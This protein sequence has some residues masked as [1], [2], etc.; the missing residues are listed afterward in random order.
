MTWNPD[1]IVVGEEFVGYVEELRETYDHAAGGVQPGSSELNMSETQSGSDEQTQTD[2]GAQLEATTETPETPAA[3]NSAMNRRAFMI[4]AGMTAATVAAGPVSAQSN[5]VINTDSEY[6]HDP[7]QVGTVTVAEH[8]PEFNHFGYINDSG[9]EATL[10]TASLAPREDEST[11][12]NPVRIRGDRILFSDRR[13]FPRDLTTTNAD[14]E[15]VDASALDAEFW[16]TDESSTAGTLTLEDASEGRLRVATSGQGAGDSAVATFTDFTLE[17]GE[18]RSMLQLILNIDT[19]DSSA[20][21]DVEVTDAASNSVVATIDSAADSANLGT[22]AT[23][24]GK[25]VIYQEQLGEFDNGANLDTIEEISVT[26]SEGNADVTFHA[27]NL[28]STSKW[29]FGTREFVNSDDEIEEK[30][31]T[32]QKGYFGIVSL[33]TL[34]ESDRLSDATLYQVE[35]PGAEIRPTD[36]FIDLA[37]AE[38][39]D[40]EERLKVVRNWDLDSAYDLT[41][42]LDRVVDDVAHPSSRYLTMEIASGLDDPVE[43]DETDDVEWTNRT[44]TYTDASIDDEVE[45]S[46]SVSSTSVF[47]HSQDVLVSADE[48]GEVVVE[49]GSGGM[50]PTGRSGGGFWSR[51]MSIPGAIATAVMG[52]GLFRWFRR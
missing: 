25:G 45:L 47:S 4:A 12:R 22:I 20:V 27:L 3:A 26:V 6:A 36:V 41:I 42:D 30:T 39:Y 32:S 49:E 38:R 33:D 13:A 9:D 5:L 40:Y 29:D 18:Q 37:E 35:Y 44:S 19:L 24:Q 10:E 21:V 50:G 52:L 2:G 31:V 46:T 15:E 34:Y 1:G 17:D 14:D 51:V 11:A 43:L 23:S 7:R 16:S 48:S 28:E 8:E